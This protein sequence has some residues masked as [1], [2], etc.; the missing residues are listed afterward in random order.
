MTYRG[1]TP[2]LLI[3]P[4]LPV[5]NVQSKKKKKMNILFLTFTFLNCRSNIYIFIPRISIIPST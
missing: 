1:V 2:I 5:R 3:L 4:M